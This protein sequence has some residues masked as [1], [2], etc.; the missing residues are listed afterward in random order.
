M[1]EGKAQAWFTDESAWAVAHS[2]VAL[3]DGDEPEWLTLDDLVFH[4]GWTDQWCCDGV[5]AAQRH[6]TGN[7]QR[8]NLNRTIYDP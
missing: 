4:S 5:V 6:R 7:W 8:Q 2:W 1:A 3:K